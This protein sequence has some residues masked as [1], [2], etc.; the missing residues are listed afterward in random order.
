MPTL[1]DHVYSDV[2][3]VG[4]GFDLDLGLPTSYNDFLGSNQFE[5]LERSGNNF[6]H[7]LR[8]VQQDQRWVDI[9][10]ELAMYSE[11]AATAYETTDFLREYQ[12]LCRALSDYISCL[13]YD[14]INKNSRAATVLA[15]IATDAKE[16]CVV[17]FNYSRSLEILLPRG[18]SVNVIQVHG[19]AARRNI[20]FG[21]HDAAEITKDHIFLRKSAAPAFF[22]DC[23]I[24][25]ILKN[26]YQS[27]TVFGHSL[28]QSDH[29]QF[30]EF[31]N[32]IQN[33]K[34]SKI[35]IHYHSETSYYDLMQQIET[36]SAA[37]LL[38]F[39]TMH[40]FHM[41]GPQFS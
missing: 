8:S 23:L 16:L 28:G 18:P 26:A 21:V 31:F 5:S 39:R 1:E 25:D 19:A 11:Y 14:L 7:H 27:V 41:T 20:V 33:K 4:N 22:D 9:E 34:E 2:L 13:D 10:I 30:R 12:G 37:K 6:A 32:P 38:K 29:T 35:Q 3:V 17:N 24:S 36:M 15:G 40:D